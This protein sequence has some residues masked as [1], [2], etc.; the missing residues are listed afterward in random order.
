MR[1]RL[2]LVSILLAAVLWLPGQPGQASAAV[3]EGAQ[4]AET[5]IP[6][7]GLTVSED[8]PEEELTF[9]EE[10]DPED[11]FAAYAEDKLYEGVRQQAILMKKTS[12]SY[13]SGQ[14]ASIYQSLIKQIRMVADGQLQSTKLEV[15][16]EELGVAD[17]ACTAQELGVEAVVV[18]DKIVAEARDLFVSRFLNYKISL[19]M[20]SLLADCPYDLYW[21]DKTR[22]LR[23]GGIKVSAKWAAVDGE[24]QYVLTFSNPLTVSFTVADEFAADTYQVDLASGQTVALAAENASAIVAEC[25]GLTDYEKLDSYRERICQETSYNFDAAE[26]TDLPYGNPWQLLWVFDGDPATTVVCEGYAKAFQYLCD[27]SSF[28]SSQTGSILVF[29]QMGAGHMWNVVTMPDGFN[30]LVDVTNCDTGMAGAD[31]GLFLAGS[32]DGSVQDG[33]TVRCGNRSF[34]YQYSNGTKDIFSEDDLTLAPASYE[35]MHYVPVSSILLDREE[36]QMPTSLTTTDADRT[37]LQASTLQ[38]TA[39]VLPKDTPDR[40]LVWFSSA[41]GVAS[42]DDAGLVTAWTCGTAVITARTTDG[43][44][45]ASC[46]IRTLYNDVTDSS[47][48]WYDPVYWAAGENITKGYGNVYFGP[49]ETCSREQLITFLW[50]MMGSPDPGASVKN[51]FSDVKNGQ[52]YYKAV[53]WA[54]EKGITN[55]YSSGPY[56]GMFGVGL[57]VSR[58]DTVTFLYRAAGKPSY[59]GESSFTD[60]S[61]GKYYYKAIMWA[62]E[63][64]ITKGYSSGPYKGMFG[65]GLDVLR[66]DIMTFMYRYSKSS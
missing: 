6:D 48:Y 28:Q 5:D 50:R 15:S 63:K 35:E 49:E 4:I 1:R 42:V 45:S 62:A 29:G 46:T 23:S 56:Q 14:N 12:G 51:T 8:L 7:G 17:L 9:S 27:L 36:A 40:E 26:Q 41:P 65:V 61:K 53:L 38:L 13:L 25:E 30:Y 24:D 22:G 11:L 44:Q 31:R 64:G 19:V 21:F 33:Y 2:L 59:A 39:Q 34:F 16:L 58:E 32:G 52:Y 37:L 47:R 43:S 55:G 54:K 20:S 60:V 66:K 18:N 3:L 57:P 10:E